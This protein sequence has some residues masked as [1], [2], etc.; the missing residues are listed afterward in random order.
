MDFPDE[1]IGGIAK[2]EARTTKKDTLYTHLK[3]LAS[4]LG[5]EYRERAAAYLA[6][7]P[8]VLELDNKLCDIARDQWTDWHWRP[9]NSLIHETV[10]M[11]APPKLPVVSF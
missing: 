4:L 2:V 9:D 6:T 1:T 7:G 10:R 3:P 8:T 5:Q 11:L